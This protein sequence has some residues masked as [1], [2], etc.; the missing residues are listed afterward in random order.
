MPKCMKLSISFFAINFILLFAVISFIL[1]VFDLHRFAFVLE[2]GMLLVL[3]FFLAFAIF[4]VYHDKK[5]GWTLTGAVLVFLLLNIFFI[6]F[7]TKT[8]D[9][10][11]MT[12]ALFSI[13]GLALAFF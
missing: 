12:A 1:I 5:W 3:L 10:A 9:T 6:Y 8:F 4:A 2:L 7:L 11:Y 13:A